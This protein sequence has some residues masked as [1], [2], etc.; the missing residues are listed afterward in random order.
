M[1]LQ[2]VGSG[3]SATG[4]L[5]G[6]FAQQKALSYQGQVASNNATIANEKAQYATE[7]GAARAEAQGIKG[8]QQLGGVRTGLAAN[9]LDVNSGS[10]A[11]VQ[12]SQR[13]TGLLDT[14]NVTHQAALAAYGYQTQ[15]TNDLAQAKLLHDESDLAPIQ[16]GIEAASAAT[17]S[18]SAQNWFGS[19]GSAPAGASSSGDQTFAPGATGAPSQLSGGSDVPDVPDEYAWMAENGGGDIY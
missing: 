15:A 17:G 1:S 11:D 6:G 7:A 8:R 9:N 12:V 14:Q 18:Q 13:E 16:G 5:L 4:D 10:A 2:D 19:I 3:I